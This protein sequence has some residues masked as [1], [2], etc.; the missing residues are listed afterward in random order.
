MHQTVEHVDSSSLRGMLYQVA[1]LVQVT[2]E[3]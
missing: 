1:H 2:E 3:A